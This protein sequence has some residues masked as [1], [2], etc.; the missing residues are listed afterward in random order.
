MSSTSA[1]SADEFSRIHAEFLRLQGA[2]SVLESDEAFTYLNKALPTLADNLAY[3]YWKKHKPTLNTSDFE[4]INNEYMR[5]G[6]GK[7]YSEAHE[8][9]EYLSKA[10]PTDSDLANYQKW[11]CAKTESRVSILSAFEPEIPPAEE[12]IFTIANA[13][14]NDNGKIAQVI[15]MLDLPAAPYIGLGTCE[16]LGYRLVP[17]PQVLTHS[18]DPDCSGKNGSKL[19]PEA[20]LGV[21]FNC[22]PSTQGT[23]RSRRQNFSEEPN[24]S[25]N[26]DNAETNGFVLFQL[27]HLEVYSGYWD[28]VKDKQEYLVAQEEWS[29]TG[30]AVVVKLSQYGTTKDIYIM[31]NFN[32]LSE[33]EG[34]RTMRQGDV[35]GKLGDGHSQV[36][37][38]RIAEHI[39]DLGHDKPFALD[40]I[41]QVVPEYVRVIR[42]LDGLI[43]RQAVFKGQ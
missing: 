10:F 31:F 28:D 33:I 34:E 27:G 20:F 4:R 12:Y 22:E 14:F 21:N 8:A 11:L 25:A 42:R 24:T 37:C 32:P 36:T 39:K 40:L 30:F 29:D 5:L 41:H 9:S 26:S 7:R 43:L 18:K 13:T 19:L 16:G 23:S 15:E 3:T 17:N 35:W 6:E 1:L 38:A 2:K